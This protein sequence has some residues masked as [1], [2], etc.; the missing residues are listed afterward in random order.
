MFNYSTSA[1]IEAVQIDA[2]G[3]WLVLDRT[4]F[5][6]QGGGQPSDTGFITAND[7]RFAVRQVRYADGQVQHIG[8]IVQGEPTAGLS[9]MLNVDP[10]RREENSRLQSGGHLILN[11]M[12]NADQPFV[13]TKGYHFPDGPYVEFDGI[14]PENERD[15]LTAQLQTEVDRLIALD[16]PVVA[17]IVRPDELQSLCRNVPAN[18]PMDKPSRIVIIDG[19]AQPCGGTH[20]LTLGKLAGMRIEKVRAKKGVTRV[21]YSFPRTVQ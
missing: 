14:V 8:N 16:L 17:R 12:A 11:A 21:S 20:V 4:I 15:T 1:T 3:T 7:F 18:V 2:T 10:A 19:F 6:P 5:Y 13:A 9:V